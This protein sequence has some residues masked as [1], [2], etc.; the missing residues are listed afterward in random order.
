MLAEN[1][2]KMLVSKI[3]NAERDGKPISMEKI[4]GSNGREDTINQYIQEA[5]K[6]INGFIKAIG[7]RNAKL[8]LA[9]QQYNN[10]ETRAK[11]EVSKKDAELKKLEA[12][13][14]LL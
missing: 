6:F 2:I 11:E 5:I 3:S 14:T 9:N 8:N 10:L 7:D 4:I 13:I 1:T 12:S